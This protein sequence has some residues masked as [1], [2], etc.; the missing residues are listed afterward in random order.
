MTDDN[1]YDEAAGPLVRPY[2]ITSG[3][4]PSE[5][6]QLDVSTQVMTLQSEQEPAGLGPEHLAITRLCR[7]PLSVAEIAVYVKL[8]LG[9]VRVLCGDLI[10]RG[11]VIT[12][13]PSHQPA[14]APDHETLQAVLDGLIKL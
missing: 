9:V 11:L 6:A 2:T 5:G 8:P 3:R 4:T 10:E 7:R 12:R 14:Q 1:W 13:S